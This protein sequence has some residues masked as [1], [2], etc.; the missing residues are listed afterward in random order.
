MSRIRFVCPYTHTALETTAE[1]LRTVEGR[2]Y[3]IRTAGG[4]GFADFVD[5]VGGDSRGQSLQMY[6]TATA[7]AIYQNFLDWMFAT[8]RIEE[9]A[10]R[11]DL[12]WRLGARP[13]DAV[14]ITGC[15]LGDDI[16]SILDIIGPTGEVHAQDLSAT[17][18]AAAAAR[19]AQAA[20][21]RV[22]QVTFS[23]SDAC[24]LPYAD[25]V[26][27]AAYH[28]GGINLFDDVG[29]GVAE[30]ARVVRT[31]GRILVSDEGVAPWLR[32]TGYGKMVITN[33]HLWAH[34][35]PLALLPQN[36]ADVSLTW[37]LGACFWVI[38]FGLASGPPEIDPHVVHKGR[39]GGTMWTRHVGALEAVTPQT[40]A[41]VLAAAAAEGMSVHDWMERAFQAALPS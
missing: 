23:V 14:L 6:D 33:N 17:M 37:V 5:D 19:L 25:G 31:G 11:A 9:Q 16:L 3:G 7:E 4:A 10:F 36:A 27:D 2:V 26:F 28:F 35:A 29:A 8:F 39:R 22:G 18:V 38:T 15:G 40:K 21:E 32:D 41:Q 30:M 20:P 12:A 13:G 24:R 34:Q 1:T